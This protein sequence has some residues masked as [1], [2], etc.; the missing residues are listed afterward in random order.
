MLLNNQE[1]PWNQ[2]CLENRPER[3][4]KFSAF[5]DEAEEVANRAGCLYVWAEK[6]TC[7]FLPEKLEARGYDRVCRGDGNINPDYVKVL[8][9]GS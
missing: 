6:L 7:E 5:M 1:R 9:Q 3:T 4:G 2:I 8:R